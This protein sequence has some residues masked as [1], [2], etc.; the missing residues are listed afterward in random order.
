MKIMLSG[1]GHPLLLT[2]VLFAT[3]CHAQN[4][5]L[6]PL[7]YDYN[8]LEPHIDEATMRAHHL[9]HHQTYTDKLNAA[10]TT[11]RGDLTQKHLAK[12]SKLVAPLGVHIPGFEVELERFHGG[13]DGAWE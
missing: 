9:S 11:L 2:L 5:P 12:M 3:A 4:L 7:P 8:A 10:L 1:S 13:G 6:P